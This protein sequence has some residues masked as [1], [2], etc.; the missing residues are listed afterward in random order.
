MEELERQGSNAD[1]L[2]DQLL[3]DP[4]FP[5]RCQE[6]IAHLLPPVEA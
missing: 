6:F 5:H 4:V 2:V 3:I 1:Q